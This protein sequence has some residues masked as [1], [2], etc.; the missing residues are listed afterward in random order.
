MACKGLTVWSLPALPLHLGSLLPHCLNVSHFS[1]YSFSLYQALS[2]LR[3]S[4]RCH[5]P[6]WE[7]SSSFTS[8]GKCLSLGKPSL[9]LWCHPVLLW[10]TRNMYLVIRIVYY[11]YFNSQGSK[12]RS[13]TA[14][15]WRMTGWWL[16]LVTSL[17]LS[18]HRCHHAGQAVTDHVW[19]E[20]FQH[21]RDVLQ[22]L[23]QATVYLPFS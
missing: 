12:S 5:L 15:S 9:T 21:C 2:C 22:V 20:L 6:P 23:V 3:T 11:Y 10:L 13:Q 7:F 1:L 4:L 18:L 19:E 8:Q 16:W 14:V 17:A